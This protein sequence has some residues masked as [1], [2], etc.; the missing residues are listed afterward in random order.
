MGAGNM[1]LQV[2]NW[3]G[4]ARVSWL[5]RLV[6]QLTYVP[7]FTF[8]FVLSL[9]HPIAYI[10]VYSPPTIHNPPPGFEVTQPPLTRSIPPPTL[11]LTHPIPHRPLLTPRFCPYTDILTIPHA[12]GLSSILV[13]GVGIANFDSREA[14]P[15][16]SSKERRE[17]EVHA[18]L[19]KIEGTM[20]GVGD[21]TIGTLAT[22]TTTAT[23]SEG[24]IGAEEIGKGGVV[25]SFTRLKRWERLRV[26]GKMD[27]TEERDSADEG[28]REDIGDVEKRKEDKE[29]REKMKMR[30]KGKSL[31]RYYNNFNSLVIFSLCSRSSHSDT[32][33]NNAKTSS[34][35]P[36]YV[37]SFLY[38]TVFVFFFTQCGFCLYKV[39]IRAK[40]EKQR[41]ERREVLAVARGE[42]K[43]EKKKSALDRFKRKPQS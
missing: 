19:E 18:L 10:Q 36:W 13:P 34:T 7:F 8:L 23:G 5:S 9:M 25:D 32:S 31:K 42:G 3:S 43:G 41:A 22:T 20:V 4:L 17:R 2:Q 30:G 21:G 39:A 33:A 37:F 1:V 24:K 38:C 27:E 26:S 6:G 14:D 15:F 28:V 12:S 35:L 16:E 40:L 11:Y 29:K